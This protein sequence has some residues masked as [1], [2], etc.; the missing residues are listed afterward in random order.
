M[1][2]K[3]GLII[4]NAYAY[5]PQFI[6]QSKKI[7][8]ELEKLHI[9]MDIK[10]NDEFFCYIN[11]NGKIITSL[12]NY[13]FCVF[14][15]KDKYIS[16]LLEK[17]GMRLFNSG[18][19]IAL[20]DDKMDT[21]I[22]LSNKG[23]PLIKTLP[24]LFS[25]SPNARLKA[26]SLKKIHHELTY[27]LIIKKA[28]S[29]LGKGV[30]LIH[31]DQELRNLYNDIKLE[32]FILQEFI[33]DSYGTDIRVILIGKKVIGAMKRIANNDFRSNIALGGKGIKINPDEKLVHLCENVATI[34]NLD[35]CGI[36]V[37]IKKD[38]SY[39]IC[40]VNSNAFFNKFEEVTAINV[41][42]LY[43]EYIYKIIYE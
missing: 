3:R 28:Y 19:A 18:S 4:L 5:L 13:D 31:N 7:K 32:P 16:F 22:A 27:P 42:K 35:Y 2:N 6:S 14:L 17:T 37:L 39:L 36:D 12:S 21:Y 30:Y 24:G 9:Q 11:Q 25:Y 43:A 40:E 8:I 26:I 1:K 10:R 41:A 33:E 38:G 23:I 29:S 34:L 15:D 20:C